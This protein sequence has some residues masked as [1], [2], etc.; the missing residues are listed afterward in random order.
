LSTFFNKKSSDNVLLIE[1]LKDQVMLT[2]DIDILKNQ[3]YSLFR[4]W[5]VEPPSTGSLKRMIDSAIDTF[6]KDLYQS[7]F[8]QLSSKT[9]SLG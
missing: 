9:C 5:K 2:H 1:W 8:Q 6:E 7:T 3:V 4:K